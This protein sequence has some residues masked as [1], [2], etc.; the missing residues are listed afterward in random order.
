ML[1]TRAR[2]IKYYVLM[3]S[4]VPW[5]KNKAKQKN[6]NFVWAAVYL[7]VAHLGFFFE[8]DKRAAVKK[9]KR[10][11]NALLEG[12]THSIWKNEEMQSDKQQNDEENDKTIVGW[13]PRSSFFF[14]LIVWVPVSIKTETRLYLIINCEEKNR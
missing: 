9:K 13:R 3:A 8:K 4:G 6:L 11:T 5:R 2:D 1:K 14:I 12:I 10:Y 7:P